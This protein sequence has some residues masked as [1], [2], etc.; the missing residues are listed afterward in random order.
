M[1]R[2]VSLPLPV[3]AFSAATWRQEAVLCMSDPNGHDVH[4][5]WNSMGIKRLAH[6]CSILDPW[7]NFFWRPSQ[8]Q[9]WE[10]CVCF[11]LDNVISL[12]VPSTPQWVTGWVRVRSRGVVMVQPSGEA[13]SR[14]GRT[15]STRLCL[16]DRSCFLDPRTGGGWRTVLQQ[17]VTKQYRPTTLG[18]ENVQQVW[19]ET[20]PSQQLQLQLL[21]FFPGVNSTQNLLVVVYCYH[22]NN[23]VTR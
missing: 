14:D 2:W 1:F 15:Q 17:T 16:S 4:S 7:L 12:F 19:L 11:G 18:G 22:S 21:W 23:N 13:C 20:H 9:S 6:C 8:F 5:S 3:T 10:T